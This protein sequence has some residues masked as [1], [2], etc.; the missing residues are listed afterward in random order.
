MTTAPVC[1]GR[2]AKHSPISRMMPSL[3]ALRLAG[4]FRPTVKTAP[5]FSIVRSEL[6][7]AAAASAF[8]CVI[9]VLVRIAMLYYEFGR[10]QY[11]TRLRYSG[12]RPGGYKASL[13]FGVVPAKAGTHNPEERFGD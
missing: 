9:C 11:G 4:R 7:P 6:V 12:C 1:S 2:D 10:S 8:P 13:K 3:S 5:T